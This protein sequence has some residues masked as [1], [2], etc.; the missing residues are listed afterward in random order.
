VWTF[1]IP[2]RL[3]C[4]GATAACL[5]SCYAAK[6]HFRRPSVA[7]KYARNLRAA[8]RP[9][10]VNQMVRELRAHRVETLRVHVAGDFETAEYVEKWT[11]IAARSPQTAFYAYTRSWRVSHLRGPLRK[12]AALP[13]VHLWLSADK[14]SGRPPEWKAARIA[15][16]MT[17]AEADA[18]AWADL[19]FRVTRL[20]SQK[21]TPSG[22]LV[23]PVEQGVPRTVPIT[24]SSCRLCFTA[25]PVPSRTGS[26]ARP[27]AGGPKRPPRS[28]RPRG[29][30]APQPA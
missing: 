10:F 24:C 12:L 17:P 28:R 21:Y 29:R 25:R 30:R 27:A 16:M 11:E 1:S 23:C 2:A 8:R 20:S 13:N 9:G 18:P 22:V 26:P 5:K 3:T 15:Y 7:D 4:P 6:G 19:A 14:D